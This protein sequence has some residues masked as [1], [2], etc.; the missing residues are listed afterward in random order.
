MEREDPGNPGP[1]PPSR[2]VLSPAVILAA[3]AMVG[4]GIGGAFLV[5][6]FV[7][8]A[9]VKP[10][11]ADATTVAA[12]SAQD[13]AVVPAASDVALPEDVGAEPSGV[14]AAATATPDDATPDATPVPA[15]PDAEVV[16]PT[17]AVDAA[18]VAVG[19]YALT[20]F[21]FRTRGP[22]DPLKVF[23]WKQVDVDLDGVVGDVV[24]ELDFKNCPHDTDGRL[25]SPSGQIIL[26]WSERGS[27]R[28][29]DEVQGAF[30]D[31]LEPLESLCA[32]RGEP[33]RGAWRLRI[34]D[35][36][37]PCRALLR[38]GRLIF[39]PPTRTCPPP[40]EP[41]VP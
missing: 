18:G 9:T 19:E 23:S 28:D 1:R 40:A 13:V 32:L 24:V 38:T 35:S 14:E 25:V 8:S 22:D 11:A 6:K 27:T 5:D 12:R 41:A 4:A 36:Q 2:G 39:Q 26:L 21:S 16:E 30:P 20:E 10:R 29:W 34:G 3:I 15:E 7:L 31:S 33:A 37:R 17:A